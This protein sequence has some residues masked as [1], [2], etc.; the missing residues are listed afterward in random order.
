MIDDEHGATDSV[1]APQSPLA[2]FT[3]RLNE[4]GYPFHYAVTERTRTLFDSRRSSFEF[5]GA[6][7]PVEL[8]GRESRIDTVLRKRTRVWGRSDSRVAVWHIVIECKRANPALANWCFAK[9]PYVRRGDGYESF[10]VDT[11]ERAADSDEFVLHAARVHGLD[12]AYHIAFEAKTHKK[13]D[14][15]GK[16]GAIEDAISQALRGS[17]G[18]VD[19][20]ARATADFTNVQK[21][22]FV[23]I[24]VTTAALW[25]TDAALEEADA[26]TGELDPSSVDFERV[27]SVAMQYSRSHSLTPARPKRSEPV[28]DLTELFDL[29]FARTV[30]IMNA[31]ALDNYL[32]RISSLA[33]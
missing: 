29:E 13:G 3:H 30:H 19:Q 11:I 12:P 8:R 25:V 17:A 10:T 32:L 15:A 26:A 5:Q 7:F 33:D 9:A 1:A 16:S 23:P 2:G 22:T 21:V 14:P 28:T 4:H 24:V 20:Y 27:V 31:N 6:E 18:L